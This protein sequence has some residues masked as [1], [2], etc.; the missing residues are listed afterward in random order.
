MGPP[1]FHY[2]YWMWLI[3]FF[4][5]YYHQTWLPNIQVSVI[6]LTRSIPEGTCEVW[7]CLDLS[8][9]LSE[10]DPSQCLCPEQLSPLGS[11]SHINLR[12]LGKNWGA[13]GRNGIRERSRNWSSQLLHRIR[14]GWH[15]SSV[16]IKTSQQLTKEGGVMRKCNRWQRSFSSN[17]LFES[18]YSHKEC[19]GEDWARLN[20]WVSFN[21][22]RTAIHESLSIQE[23]ENPIVSLEPG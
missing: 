13:A 8:T 10:Q 4:I 22:E 20:W 21:R 14:A 17:S 9:I 15:W 5:L 7:R 18:P 23:A 11:R 2:C 16:S 12:L 6:P 3:L 1:P 19:A